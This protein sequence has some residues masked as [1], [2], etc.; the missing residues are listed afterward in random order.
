MNYCSVA[1]IEMFV[2]RAH[3]ISSLYEGHKLNGILFLLYRVNVVKKV[4]LD[5][6][7]LRYV[8]CRHW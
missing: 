3:S 5:E 4:L 1:F 2:L 6:M 8:F 7:A